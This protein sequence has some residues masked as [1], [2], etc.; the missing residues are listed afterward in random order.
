[1]HPTVDPAISHQYHTAVGGNC[2]V[3]AGDG[4][5]GERGPQVVP[6]LHLGL[7]DAKLGWC[8]PRDA[9]DVS[10]WGAFCNVEKNSQNCHNFCRVS[11]KAQLLTIGVVSIKY[12]AKMDQKTDRLLNGIEKR[13]IL[14][15]K[16]DM[17]ESAPHSEAWAYTTT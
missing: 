12:P 11:E 4:G 1:M 15:M 3:V 8:H 13:A 6:A 9:V 7:R 2:G 16:A 10:C 17:V 5:A 14:L